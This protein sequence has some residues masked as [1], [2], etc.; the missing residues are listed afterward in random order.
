MNSTFFV[1]KLGLGKEVVS[2]QM[3]LALY[4]KARKYFP[5]L[6]SS[7]TEPVLY[8]IWDVF[9]SMRGRAKLISAIVH[10]VVSFIVILITFCQ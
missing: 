2:G 8:N 6:Q 5:F 9:F 10:D 4:F 1:R 3:Y 7:S